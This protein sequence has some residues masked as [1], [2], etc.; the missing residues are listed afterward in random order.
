[1]P[2]SLAQ[3]KREARERMRVMGFVLKQIWVHPADWPAVLRMV[4]RFRKR[5]ERSSTSTD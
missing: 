2:K 3:K 1:M 4:A 5:R